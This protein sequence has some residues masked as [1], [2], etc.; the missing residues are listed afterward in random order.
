MH[1]KLGIFSY[2]TKGI[3][4]HIAHSCGQVSMCMQGVL[5]SS[6]LIK[7]EHFSSLKGGGFEFTNIPILCQNH[8]KTIAHYHITHHPSFLHYPNHLLV[9]FPLHQSCFSSCRHVICKGATT[10]Q[11]EEKEEHEFSKWREC[12][13]RM[14]VFVF[15]WFSWID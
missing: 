2:T 10:H 13:I 4:W 15:I 14:L 1:P 3:P 12:L 7:W 8:T 6:F 11:V 5:L 9:P